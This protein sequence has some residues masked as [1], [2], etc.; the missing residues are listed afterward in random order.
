MPGLKTT[1]SGDAVA[2]VTVGMGVVT[3]EGYQES[4]GEAKQAARSP[5]YYL[6]Y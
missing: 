6:F 4:A 3:T 2:G 5:R 1:V